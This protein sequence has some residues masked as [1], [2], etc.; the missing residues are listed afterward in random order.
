MSILRAFVGPRVTRSPNL[1]RFQPKSPASL[2][3][4]VSVESSRNC[5]VLSLSEHW[6]SPFS[7]QYLTP[8][9]PLTYHSFS[10]FCSVLFPSYPSIYILYLFSFTVHESRL[11][12]VTDAKNKDTEF[13]TCQCLLPGIILNCLKLNGWNVIRSLYKQTESTPYTVLYWFRGCLGPVFTAE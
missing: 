8:P 4:S 9:P 5:L 6:Y 13:E 2:S 7:D 1:I 3:L 10:F 11:I 12:Q